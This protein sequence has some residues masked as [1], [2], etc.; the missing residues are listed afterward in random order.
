MT[1]LRVM[2]TQ[3]PVRVGDLA[4]NATAIAAAARRAE[5]GGRRRPAHPGDGRDRVPVRGP[6]RRAGLRRRCP[7][8][9]PRPWPR[10]SATTV[11]IVGA[12]WRADELPTAGGARAEAWAADAAPRSLRNAA[13]AAARRAGRRRAREEPPAHVL[14][15]RRRPSLRRRRARPGAVPGARPSTDPSCSRSWS[16]RTRGTPRWSPR[17]RRPVRRSSSSRTPARTTSASPP[18]AWPSCGPPRRPPAPRWRTSTPVGGQDELVFDGGSLV[19]DADGRVLAR[20]A[21]VRSRRA[22]RRHPGRTRPP[23]AARPSSTSAPPHRTARSSRPPTS[24]TSSTWTPRSTRPWSPGSA[25]TADA[26]ACRASCSACPAAST[27]RSPRPSRSTPSGAENVWGIGMPGPYSSAGSV[28]DARELA[29]NLGIRFDVVPIKDA[30][31]ERHAV[32]DGLVA[33]VAGAAVAPRTRSRG[34][35]SRRGCAARR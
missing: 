21:G 16:A 12:P 35:T 2:L 32:L 24:R 9:R 33:D 25:T 14:R 26:R 6:A 15:V 19:V 34:R 23:G 22:R 13:V 8:R 1:H 5:R 17:S 3:L 28:D 31:L 18:C 4:G 7:G 30:Y 20:G 11:A 29:E 10:A 27:P